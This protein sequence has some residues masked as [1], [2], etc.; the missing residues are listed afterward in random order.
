M[1]RILNNQY[2]IVC[3]VALSENNI[4]GDGTKLP[5]HLPEDLKRVKKMTIGNP[6]IMGRKTYNSIGRPLPG[7]ANIVLTRKIDWF[8]DDIIIANSFYQSIQKANSWIDKN[9]DNKEKK[10]KNIYI[11]GGS[12]I[13]NIAIRYCSKI[14]MTLVNTYIQS[15]IKFPKI[16]KK[17][18]KISCLEKKEDKVSNLS[19]SYWSYTRLV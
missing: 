13:Y 2:P 5:W 18:W 12:E 4:I 10:D 8:A 6:L 7:R 14:E 1:D 9:F 15:G 17:D 19:Y 11:F 3:I 16:K